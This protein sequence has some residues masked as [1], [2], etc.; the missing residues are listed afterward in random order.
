MRISY[1]C[2][3]EP[4][5]SQDLELLFS[6]ITEQLSKCSQDLTQS[7]QLCYH[8]IYLLLRIQARTAGVEK[9]RKLFA[10][11]IS[12]IQPLS[13][14]QVTG[15]SSGGTHNKTSTQEDHKKAGKASEL[16]KACLD[17]M[18]YEQGYGSWI[19][20]NWKDHFHADSSIFPDDLVETLGKLN[21]R[22]RRD[23]LYRLREL[24]E[25]RQGDESAEASEAELQSEHNEKAIS[26]RLGTGVGSSDQESPVDDKNM[27]IDG[28]REGV[29]GLAVGDG[30]SVKL[31]GVTGTE[32]QLALIC[33]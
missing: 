19:Y 29:V 15:Q 6:V 16:T 26:G 7:L 18:S 27:E 32:V 30:R 12:Q 5:V 17:L 8:T 13:P 10:P 24:E 11:I 4:L 2:L 33:L 21:V 14:G 3:L 31:E 20:E 22:Q 9:C 28:N 25:R 1:L 23:K